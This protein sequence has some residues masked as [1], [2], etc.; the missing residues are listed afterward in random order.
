[1]HNCVEALELGG[2]RHERPAR[3]RGELFRLA[4]VA[5]A[6]EERVEPDDVVARILQ[7]RCEDRADIA[8]VPCDEYPH[9]QRPSYASLSRSDS[10]RHVNASA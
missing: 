8:V 6:V 2:G 3:V 5:A 1:M 4:E 7:H 10:F 9:L